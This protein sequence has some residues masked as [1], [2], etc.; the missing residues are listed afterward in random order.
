VS[1]IF[2]S[3]SSTDSREAVALKFWLSEQRPELANEIFLDIDPNTGIRLGEQWSRQLFT[4]NSRCEY[5]ICLLSPSWEQSHECKTEYRTAEGLGKRIIVARLQDLGHT[6]ITSHWQRCDLFAKGEQTT[7]EVAGGA[8]VCFNTAALLQLRRALEGPGVGAEDFVWP[9]GTDPNRA[10]YRGWL[11]FEDIDAGVFFGRDAAIAQGLDELRALRFRELARM[12]GLKSLFVVLG[13]S[14]SGKSSFLRAGLIPR[15]QRDDRR[16][17][18]LGIVRPQR[19]AVTGDQG[20]AAAIEKARDTLRLPDISLGDIKAACRRGPEDVCDVLSRLR[21]AAVKRLGETASPPTQ[22]LGPADDEPPEASAPTLVLPLDQAEEL[23]SADAGEEAETFLELLAGLLSRMNATEVG[24]IVAATIRTDRYEAMQNHPALEGIGAVLFNELKPMPA[25]QFRDVIAGPAKRSAEGARPLTVEPQLISRLI[26]DAGAG[27]DTLPLL[28]L[29][30]ERLYTD[31]A[32]TGTLTI[33][34]YEASGGMQEVVNNEI[35]KILPTNPE[36]RQDALQLLRAAFIPWLATVN[37]DDDQFMRMSARYVD[38]PEASRPLID[39]FVERRLLVKDTRDGQVMVEVALESL[40][41]QW[42]QLADWLREERQR[43]KTA[44]DV[45]RSAQAWETHECDPAWLLTGTRLSDAETLAHT[46]GFDSRLS[47]ARQYLAASREAENEKL[48]AERRHRESR[49]RQARERVRYAAII[50]V[51]AVVGAAAAG[52]G[53]VQATNA[54]H[55]AQDLARRA[56]ASRLVSEAEDML[57]GHRSGG[58]VQA[59]QQLLAAHA[60]TGQQPDGGLLDGAIKRMTTAKIADVGTPVHSVAF[61]PDGHR[62]ATGG[63][64]GAVRLW[65]ADT[66]QPS[67]ASLTPEQSAQRSIVHP[68]S[69]TV[70]FSPDG[71]RLAAGGYD[72]MIRMWNADTGQ[73]LGAPIKSDTLEVMSLVFSRDG[74]FLASTGFDATAVRIW[75]VDSGQPAGPPIT[76]PAAQVDS[77]A[78]SPDGHRLATGSGDATVRLWDVDTGQPSAVPMTVGQGGVFNVTF[79]PDGHRLISCCGADHKVRSWNADTGQPAGDFDIGGASGL[80]FSADASRVATAGPGNVIRL[81]DTASGQPVGAPLA[82]HTDLVQT[83]AFSIDGQR[84]LSGGKDQTVRVWNLVAGAPLIG[85]TDNVD[86]AAFSP[87]GHF[88]ASG[89]GALDPTVRL[90]DTQTRQEVGGP[91]TGHTNR[92]FSVVFSPDGHRIASSS[93]DNTIRLWKADTGQPIGQPLAAGAKPFDVVAF[94]PDGRRLISVTNAVRSWDADTGETVGTPI[95]LQINGPSMAAAISADRR[96]VAIG[97][98]ANN[99]IQLFNADTGQPIGAPMS[100]HTNGPT[101]LAFSPDGR[102]LVSGGFDAT[103]RLWDVASGKQ[104]GNALTGHTSAVKSVAFSPDGVVIASGDQNGEV[105]LWNSRT[106]QEL[107][108]PFTGHS[109]EV[110]GLAFR[111][112]GHQLASAS[113]DRTIRLSPATAEPKDLCDK[114]TTDIRATQ[115][116]D[117]VSPDI[118]YQRLCPGLPPPPE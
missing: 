95:T 9:P 67:G 92:V 107:G 62:F 29:T 76:V 47:D 24:F 50:A 87:D 32:S 56:I 108:S 105:R 35:D 6:D 106:G 21:S 90:W 42:D 52:V 75:N 2:L 57:A 13:P 101:S 117:W 28:A 45:Q 39:Q 4:S 31:Y 69:M 15:L 10:P 85:H 26:N 7:I 60:L 86:V 104:I 84:L 102:R 23:F 46:A 41:R 71:H 27:A 89:G 70:V 73:P 37:P 99:D 77:L 61:S 36:Q 110:L 55:R 97:V 33:A 103:V 38:L 78:F 74:H 58:D 51:I 22:A 30:L 118:P 112:D 12:S 14:G 72:D 8:A 5:V 109:R 114:L 115:W 96:V 116:R 88:L 80:A 11:P 3:H 93:A 48:E 34:H 98:P 82:G 81:W 111:P 79:T 53:F 40:L 100:G 94:S 44:E 25:D 43:L 16:F 19:S 49:V 18:V 54:K 83:V 17:M 66:G 113:A 63:D 91:L 65:N 1:R 59:L 68:D 20:F 64:N